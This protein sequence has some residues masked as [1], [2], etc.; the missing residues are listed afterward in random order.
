MSKRLRLLNLSLL[1][2]VVM[3]LPLCAQESVTLTTYYPAPVGVY[4]RLVTLTLGVGDSNASGTVDAAD[5]PNPATN[6]GDAWIAGDVGLGTTNLRARL[7]VSGAA[8]VGAGLAG[9]NAI[10]API[11]GLLVEGDTG[12]GLTAPNFT[13]AADLEING[14]LMFAPGAAPV[15]SV[16]QSLEGTLYYSNS[17]NLLKY[18][19]GSTWKN[20]GGVTFGTT[21]T[22]RQSPTRLYKNENVS[23]RSTCN[24][25][26]VVTGVY[27]ISANICPNDCC[28]FGGAGRIGC[29]CGDNAEDGY[30][31][32]RI[33]RIGVIC[34]TLQ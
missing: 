21:V 13:P 6:P 23:I 14:T 30:D 9:N 24:S 4:Q 32:G 16:G 31:T 34:R 15:A 17:D 19:N 25:N 12:F 1:F 18:H 29:C 27:I 3:A 11:N 26:E 10:T 7:D 22:P 8:L 5:A 20:V 28:N 2:G 33:E